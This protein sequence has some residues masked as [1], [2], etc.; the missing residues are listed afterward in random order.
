M[1]KLNKEELYADL[2]ISHF[3]REWKIRR[4][5][6]E[7]D[8]DR[9][10]FITLQDLQITMM[11]RKMYMSDVTLSVML[12]SVAKGDQ[13]KIDYQQFLTIFAPKNT[14]NNDENIRS[15]N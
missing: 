3:L 10:G 2:V 14:N 12:G 13:D 4:A 15:A 8:V 7:M 11:K 9:D 1:N 6:L 5:F